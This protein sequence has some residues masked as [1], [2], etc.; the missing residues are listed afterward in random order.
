MTRALALLL[1]LPCALAQGSPAV[2]PL[3]NIEEL[4]AV[5]PAEALRLLRA[6]STWPVVRSYI[7]VSPESQ[8]IWCSGFGRPGGRHTTTA[9]LVYYRGNLIVAVLATPTSSALS[10]SLLRDLF[11]LPL[12][13]PEPEHVKGGFS[14]SAGYGYVFRAVLLEHSDE[15]GA[16]TTFARVTLTDP[17]TLKHAVHL[18]YQATD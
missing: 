6:S 17:A 18:L 16:A 3:L 4:R 15:G 5:P 10:P 7:G 8:L 12:E 9:R 14:W 11:A 1:L 13:L 2:A